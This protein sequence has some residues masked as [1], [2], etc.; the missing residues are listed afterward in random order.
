MENNKSS[1]TLSSPEF[2]VDSRY[3]SLDKKL[4]DGKQLMEARLKRLN[5]LS[6]SQ[7]INAKLLQLKLRM[8]DYLKQPNYQEGNFFTNFLTN[9]IDTIY[10]K[11]SM[12]AKDINITPV[13]LS[14]ILNNHREPKEEF[15]F[16]L[17]LHSELTYKHIC[18]FQ[19]KTWYQVYYHE[20]ICDTMANQN[21]WRPTEKKHVK[22]K[23]AVLK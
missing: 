18:K 23:H 17:M 3:K 11:R 6:R 1:N 2:G 12:F 13:S 22:I 5:K 15:M 10:D 8:E 4:S 21:E 14:Q 16:R 20:K 9:Y 19:K 7:V